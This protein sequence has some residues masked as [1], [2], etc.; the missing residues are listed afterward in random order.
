MRR[1][2]GITALFGFVRRLFVDSF[3]ARL[4]RKNHIIAAGKS[5]DFLPLALPVLPHFEHCKLVFL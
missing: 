4:M 1:E 2:I 5:F 3:A